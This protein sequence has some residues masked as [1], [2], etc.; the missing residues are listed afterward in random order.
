MLHYFA[1]LYY[2][3]KLFN[4]LIQSSLQPS[5]MLRF[6]NIFH[7]LIFSF[8]APNRRGSE[9]SS[10]KQPTEAELARRKNIR[11]SKGGIKVHPCQLDDVL[12]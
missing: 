3:M 9:N 12:I 2:F 7:H 4:I 1:D 5:N 11:K 6:L 8:L 10:T